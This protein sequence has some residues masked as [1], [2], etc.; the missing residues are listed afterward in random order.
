MS[1]NEVFRQSRIRTP[2]KV[3]VACGEESWTYA[4]LDGVTD[5]IASNLVAAGI[6]PGDRVALHLMNSPEFAFSY[7]GCLKAG[8]IAVPINVRMMAWNRPGGYAS[9]RLA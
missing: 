9:D 8:C 4:E 7:L 6:K 5:N 2:D 1:V 3:A